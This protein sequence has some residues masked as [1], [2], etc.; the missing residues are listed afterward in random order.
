MCIRDRHSAQ[1]RRFSRGALSKV[2]AEE[3]DNDLLEIYAACT[4]GWYGIA[5]DGVDLPCNKQNALLVYKRFRWV[6]DQVADFIR[7]R[8]NFLRSSAS[9]SPSTS[10]TTTG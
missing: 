5:V 3:L 1:N 6:V 8:A 4:L 9:D 2:R 7:D 10:P